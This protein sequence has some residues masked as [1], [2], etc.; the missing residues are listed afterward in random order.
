VSRVGSFR[1]F[2]VSDPELEVEG[3]RQVTVHSPALRARADLTLWVPEEPG[4]L[5]IVILLHGIYGSHWQWA[6]KAGAH[7]TASRLIAE[8]AL[9]PLVLA[10][11]S[12]GH[13]EDG[14]GYVRLPAADVETWIVEEVVEAT[15]AA[16]P[17]ASPE[18][19]VCV[20]GL[21]MGGFGALRLGALHPDRF[22][23]AA[24]HSSVTRLGQLDAMTAAALPD[25]GDLADVLVARRH[26]LPAIRFD[27]GVADPYLAANRALDERLTAEAIDHTYA[28][29]PGGH[30]WDYWTRRLDE[31]LR[32]FGDQLRL[33]EPMAGP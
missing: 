25:V 2:E 18:A 1:T 26:T 22:V 6:Y 11:P 29:Y 24:G 10:M 27:C 7:R 21:S 13:W 3:L 12:D 23:A 28:E 16:A 5:P 9:P 19:G 15:V 33:R 20:G 14:S 31:T 32:F 17:S 4:P 8:G 30:D